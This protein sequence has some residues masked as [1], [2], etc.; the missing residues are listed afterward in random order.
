MRRLIP[1]VACGL[2]ACAAAPAAALGHGQVYKED[3]AIVYVA[4]VVDPDPNDVRITQQIT[5]QGSFVRI[6]DPASKGGLS[7]PVQSG[8]D[9]QPG[10]AT[11]TDGST[12][13]VLCPLSGTTKISLDTNE[14][15]DKVTI[16]IAIPTSIVTGAG[17]DQVTGGPARDEINTGSGN[18]TAS[19][20]GG[21]DFINGDTGDDAIAGGD[22]KDRLQGGAG[23]DRVDGGTGDDELLVRDTFADAVACGDGADRVFAD[24]ADDVPAAAGCETVDRGEA[25]PADQGGSSSGSGSGSGSTTGSGTDGGSGGEEPS[26]PQTAATRDD[27]T[28]PR[29][30]IGGST[31]Q[32]IGRGG[33][34]RVAAVALDEPVVVQA[35]AVVSVGVRA[36]AQTSPRTAIRVRGAGAELR[37]KLAPNALKAIRRRLR[38]GRRVTAR[39]TV[40]ATDAAGNTSVASMRRVRLKR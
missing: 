28:A 35:S 24:A 7:S 20:A 6:F 3:G 15:E 31:A 27:R 8:N 13:E 21:D 18:D 33:T 14:R 38:S 5:Q 26:L 11:G 19:G 30:R 2:A 4:S 32:R 36:F 16:S 10:T 12:A 23:A 34:L 1:A 9:C 25:A 22:G 17:V 37:M 39:I 29:L 40:L